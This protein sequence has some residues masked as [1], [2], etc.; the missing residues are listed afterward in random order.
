MNVALP[1]VLLLFLL[2]PGVAFVY[3]YSGPRSSS[4]LPGF[5]ALSTNFVAAIVLSPLLHYVWIRFAEFSFPIVPDVPSA[6]FLLAGDYSNTE[7]YAHAATAASANLGWILLYFLSLLA[8]SLLLGTAVQQVV[9]YFGLDVRFGPLRFNNKWHYLFSG[10]LFNRDF[11]M[12]SGAVAGT[13]VSTLVAVGNLT[14]LYVGVLYEYEFGKDGRLEKLILTAARRRR[15]VDE[16]DKTKPK[17]KDYYRIRGDFFVLSG[18]EIKTLNIDYFY[19]DH[20]SGS[21][22]LTSELPS[23]SSDSS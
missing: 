7:R 4:N 6:M 18:H 1:G 11:E 3:A 12:G 10:E 5:P 22:T 9:R 14:Y 8:T 21:V 19:L 16:T 17:P 13:S 20:D 15:I 2:L 23:G